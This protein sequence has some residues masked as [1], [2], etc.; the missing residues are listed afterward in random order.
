ME[1]VRQ[2]VPTRS[3]RFIDQHHLRTE[4]AGDWGRRRLAVA[5]REIAHWFAIELVHD[6][7][8]N[9]AAMVV[10]LVDDGAFPLLLRVEVARERGV[11]RPRG[12]GQPHIRQPAAGQL[13]DAPPILLDPRARAQRVLVRYRYDRDG[14]RALA[15]R[16]FADADRRLM[17]SGTLEQTV[18]IRRRDERTPIYFEKVIPFGHLN[19]W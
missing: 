5:R 9:H 3:R 12:V 13:I 4:D 16:R 15:G 14:T 1:H 11:A 8:G 2:R 19:S 6:V 18:R 10:A 17:A 7:V